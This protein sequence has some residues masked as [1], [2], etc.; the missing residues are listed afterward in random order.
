MARGEVGLQAETGT[1]GR[2]LRQEKLP[3]RHRGRKKQVPVLRRYSLATWQSIEQTGY[4][5]SPHVYLMPE[6]IRIR[7]WIPWNWSYI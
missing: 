4:F 7:H 1:L 5:C 2:K 6:K 3:A